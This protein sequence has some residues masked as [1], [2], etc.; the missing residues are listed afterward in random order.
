MAKTSTLQDAFPTGAKDTAK[1]AATS[2]PIGPW[3]G[4]TLSG[5]ATQTGDILELAPTDSTDCVA[6]YSSFDTALDLTASEIYCQVTQVD[7]DS[8]VAVLRLIV[9]DSGGLNAYWTV[10]Y[11]FGTHTV[12]ASYSNF[13]SNGTAY[14]ATYNA[15]DHAWFRIRDAGSDIYWDTAPDNA[16]APGTWVNRRQLSVDGGTPGTYAAMSSV[17]VGVFASNDGSRT[18]ILYKVDNFNTSS[19]TP[20]GTSPM[21]YPR[22]VFFPV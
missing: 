19:G 8:S 16:G 3:S 21:F 18:G 15:T 17:E 1:W 12:E 9:A 10:S 2:V 13:G 5:T 22:K 6:G 20:A 11:N 14:S 7:T 4:R